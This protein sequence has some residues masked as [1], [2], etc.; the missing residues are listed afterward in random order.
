MANF[1]DKSYFVADIMLVKGDY[2]NIESYITRFE[3]DVLTYLLGYELYAA[4]V[5]GAANEPYKSLLNGEVYEISQNG[6]TKKVKWAGLKNTDL[7][8]LI[9]YYVYCE[10]LRNKVV[11]IQQV[12]AVLSKQENSSIASILG[13]I[14]SAWTRFEEL[15]GYYGQ[16]PL[17]PSAY[18]YLTAK[19]DL[20]EFECWEFTS[21]KGSINSHDL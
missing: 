18:N 7:S 20:P 16:S 11:S 8:S 2:D 1:I 6:K 10:Y 9:A 14:F 13:K 19:K 5:D 21:L 4:L 12:G 17:I 3:K 15:Y